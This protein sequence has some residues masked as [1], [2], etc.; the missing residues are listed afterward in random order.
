MQDVR[1]KQR[2]KELELKRQSWVSVEA[3]GFGRSSSENDVE[4]LTKKGLEEFLLQRPQSP[5]SRN[6]STRRSR[7]SLG[8]TADR[9]LLMYL[10]APPDDQLNK[11]NSLPRTHTRQSRPTIA[12]MKDKNEED[13]MHLNK[14]EAFQ[15][16]SPLPTVHI[17]SFGN[18][19]TAIAN[20]QN[21]QTNIDRNNN[22]PQNCQDYGDAS[23]KNT[24]LSPLA[25]SIQECELVKKL[26]KFDLQGSV[27]ENTE[28]V[29]LTDLETFEELSIHSLSLANKLLRPSK[30][31]KDSPSSIHDKDMS[32]TEEYS[33]STSTPVSKNTCTSE[34]DH[35]TIF[36]VEDT[37]E[38]SLSLDHS[39]AQSVNCKMRDT[40]VAMETKSEKVNISPDRH[41]NVDCSTGDA[42]S[43]KENA[44]KSKDHKRP[45]SVK[46][47]TSSFS[48]SNTARSNTATTKP[49]R[50]LNESE[51]ET[52][53]KVVPISKATKS[54]SIKRTEL[55]S[56]V[57]DEGKSD[58]LKQTFRHSLRAKNDN[59]PRSS[60]ITSPTAEEPKLQR[61]SSFIANTSRFQR[62]QIQRKSSVKKPAAKPVRNI[63]KPKPD[64]TKI[65][66][67][68]PKESNSTEISKPQPTTP[69]P[70][71]KTLPST[72]SFAR[73]TV[74][75]SSRRANPEQSS[76]TTGKTSTI[77]RSSSIRQSKG[78]SEP[79]TRDTNTRENGRVN[80]FNRTGSM[81][82]P[83]KGMVAV[84][85]GTA[86][87]VQKEKGIVEKSSVKLKD[88]GKATFG[89]ILKP[90]LK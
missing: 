51:H 10:E 26:Q 53:R 74:A 57:R 60:P 29:C 27:H 71:P 15:C 39:E 1:Q 25:I 78:K 2:L 58:E 32:M 70:S 24:P 72:P 54:G 3:R 30:N 90:L 45:N 36:F 46:E 84:G 63:S 83:G 9:E 64:E 59:V 22:Q 61:G 77:T 37:T 66:R 86:E 41:K 14:N 49:V 81:R 38:D 76:P 33:N 48:K 5:L 56:S 35:G 43:T 47:R 75:S 17:S 28:V 42:G 13:N 44:I 52:M 67:T 79:L 85:N 88:T 20:K 55:R 11:C 12:W 31:T 4:L 21:N 87:T 34:K 69:L 62:D 7:H 18:D 23:V 19:H 65:C 82:T 73:N 80:T 6:S 89:K 8:V 16:S 50:M 40:S 68:S